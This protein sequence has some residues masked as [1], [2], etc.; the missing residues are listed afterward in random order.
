MIYSNENKGFT[1]KDILI[2]LVVIVLFVFLL[3]W[4]FPTRANLGGLNK[5]IDILTG[6]LY[7]H[8][9]QT[10]KEAAISYYTNERLPQAINDVERLT[11]KDMLSLHL[12]VDFIDGNGNA[13]SKN[14]SYVEVI[15][16]QNEY[17]MKINLSCTDNDAYII[18]HLGCYDYCG[19]LGLCAKKEEIIVTPNV[20]ISCQYEYEKVLNGRWGDYGSWSDWSLTRVTESDYRQVESKNEVVLAGTRQVQVGTDTEVV[21]AIKTETKYCSDGFD[22]V[23]DRCVPKSSNAVGLECQSGY[24]LNSN[25]KCVGSVQRTVNPEC[26]SR[27]YTRS[28]FTC[29]RQTVSYNYSYANPTAVT[30]VKGDYIGT[31][32]GTSVPA[33][34]SSTIYETVSSDYVY[35]CSNGCAMRWIYTYKSYNAVAQGGDCP[36]GYWREGNTCV[37]SDPVQSTETVRATC[38]KGT[39]SGNVCVY[40][41]STTMEPTCPSGYEAKNGRCY[42]K[43]TNPQISV[44][45]SC[46]ADYTLSDNTCVK[47]VPVYEDQEIYENVVYYRFRERTYISGNRL[48]KWSNSQ[49]DQ[50]LFN[51]GYSLTG[52]KKCSK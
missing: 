27:D 37:H 49:N 51:E 26:P 18:V 42:P 30:Y 8:N 19:Q 28:G 32:T 23:G 12:L 50:A 10:M 1:I 45:Y 14:D 21:S 16:L 34:N 9:I 22:L 48:T 25:N 24:S 33:S 43:E 29:T 15:K 38:P 20:E 17:Q 46:S 7:G 35:D 2:Q 13:C 3:V 31:H 11:L 41:D 44:S 5:K 40:N 39:P 4:L 47:L 36:D 6:T 52:N